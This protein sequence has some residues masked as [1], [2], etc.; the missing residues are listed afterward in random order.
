MRWGGHTN[1]TPESNVHVRIR[2]VSFPQVVA[3]HRKPSA[4]E[5]NEYYQLYVGQVLE[6]DI[7]DVL[8]AQQVRMSD[9]LAGIPD[10]KV[11]YRYA[12]GK[13]TTREVVGH[14][15]DTE[16]IFVYRALRIARGDKTPLAGMEQD[17]FMAGANFE[18][19]ALSSLMDE[20]SSLRTAAIEM[21]ASF[22][23]EIMDR[24]GTASG[25]P[26]SVRAL[27]FIIAGHAEHHMK[28]LKERYL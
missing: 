18:K 23:E 25:F 14:V 16:W 27:L 8:K 21:F 22:D 15:V 10:S 17:E 26:F 7:I 20:F 3:M 24:Q 9:L 2:S 4:D 12:P 1:L 5:Y 6:G 13:W 28:V 11:S 19:R